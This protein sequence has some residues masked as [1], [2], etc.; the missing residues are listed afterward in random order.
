[1]AVRT[2]VQ[3]FGEVNGKS[4]HQYTITQ[5]EGIQVSVINYGATLTSIIVPDKNGSPGDVVLGFNDLKGYID[6]GNYYIG[7]IC[8]RY[9]NRIGN[10]SFRINGH[11][12][13]IS[14]NL[15]TNHL[16]GGFEGF[17]RKIWDA[18]ILPEENGVQFTY[19]SKDGE[20]GFPG[21]LSVTVTY[22]VSDNS[23]E[24]SY[25]ATTDKATPV[26]LTS[27]GYF[28][29]SGGKQANVLDHKI[30]INAGNIVEVGEH[31]IP[32]GQL[33][34]VNDSR[35]DF[36]EMKTIANG[37][38]ETTREGFDF[39]YVLDG[40]KDILK[41]AVILEHTSSGRR[42]TVYTTQPAVHFYSGH[43][44][45]ENM[46]YTKN[47]LVYGP[48]AGLCLETQHFPDS[49]NRPEFPNTIVQPGEVYREKT[50]YKFSRINEHLTN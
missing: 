41:K 40:E 34:P 32:T 12:Y 48:F 18:S 42:M 47:G 31:Y 36:R 2:T 28:N 23:L 20:E 10:A 26:N 33:S 30:Q 4:V 39:S 3:S 38:K 24:I 6:H 46:K 11:T 13:N 29:L 5:V 49:P 25:E 1:M 9:A 15:G 50:I 16:H 19:K 22:K 8:G 43:L 17:D 35:L 45:D 21:N 7:S 14:S 27:H 44:L 37:H